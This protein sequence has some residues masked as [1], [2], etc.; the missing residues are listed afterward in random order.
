M[1]YILGETCKVK[2]ANGRLVVQITF[3]DPKAIEGR[4]ISRW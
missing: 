2:Q 3:L 4:L 1:R